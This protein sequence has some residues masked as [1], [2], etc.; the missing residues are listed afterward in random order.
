MA[1]A[2]TYEV[3]LSKPLDPALGE[4]KGEVGG[5]SRLA[6]TGNLII[7]ATAEQIYV[8][9]HHLQFLWE[10][11]LAGSILD[12]VGSWL[13]EGSAQPFLEVGDRLLV[14]DSAFLTAHAKDNGLVRWRIPVAGAENI[15]QTAASTVIVVGSAPASEDPLERTVTKVDIDQGKVLWKQPKFGGAYFAGSHLYAHR[16]GRAAEDVVEGVF[17]K[18]PVTRW[19]LYKLS[20]GSGADRWEWFQPKAPRWIYPTGRE[21]VLLFDDEFQVV[22]SFAF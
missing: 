20:L 13:Y 10:S 15:V 2:S 3:R 21:V 16:I 6:T 7:L 17:G 9:D 4:W 12:A 1:D 14:G 22:R 11:R 5:W 18:N 19:K 8:F